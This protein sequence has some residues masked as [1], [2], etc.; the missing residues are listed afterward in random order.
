MVGETAQ[1]QP[2]GSDSQDIYEAQARLLQMLC[3]I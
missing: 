1:H 2:L 3:M